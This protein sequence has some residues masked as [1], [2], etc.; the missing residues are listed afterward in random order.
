[1]ILSHLELAHRYWASLL[2]PGD[3]V[4]DATCGNGHDSL[5]LA[6]LTEGNLLCIDIQKSALKQ[7]KEHLK[8]SLLPSHF[9]NIS[10]HLGCHSAFPSFSAPPRL[11]VYNLGYL[12]GSDKKVVTEAKTTVESLKSALDLLLPGGMLSIT[13]YSGHEAGAKEEEKVIEFSKSLNKN[14]FQVCYHQWINKLKAPSLI[15]IQKSNY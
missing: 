3:F 4:V 7:T 8:K 12:P 10:Y 11:I 9:K 13:C 15:L 1:M 2:K 6:K 5:A 14:D